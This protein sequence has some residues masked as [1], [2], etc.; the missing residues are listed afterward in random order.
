MKPWVISHHV[1]GMF[2]H[3][4]FVILLGLTIFPY[5]GSAVIAGK[6]FLLLCGDFILSNLLLLWII[7]FGRVTAL[8]SLAT[9]F[10]WEFSWQMEVI[11]IQRKKVVQNKV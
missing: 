2:L 5:Y 4:L 8:Q 1:K 6:L 3:V 7:N 10:L 9:F 11:R